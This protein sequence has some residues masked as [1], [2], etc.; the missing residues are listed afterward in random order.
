MNEDIDI[1]TELSDDE[2]Y[3]E[4]ILDHT[5]TREGDPLFL[6]KW[7]GFPEEENSWVE[8]DNICAV[9]LIEEYWKDIGGKPD[10]PINK[11]AI[12]CSKSSDSEPVYDNEYTKESTN[13]NLY[14]K[15]MINN[16]DAFPFII[17]MIT[18]P[19]IYQ[20]N[21]E[22]FVDNILAVEY[23]SNFIYIRI[24]WYIN[25]SPIYLE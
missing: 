12:K 17:P 16:K 23:S 19:T 22:E 2:F 3:V 25:S 5:W 10:P 11:N 1:E 4:K 13:E 9:N 6:L 18:D 15:P 8:Q 21:W 14:A 7:R 20:P 24:K